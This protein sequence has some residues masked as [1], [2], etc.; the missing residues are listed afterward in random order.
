M[1]WP[2]AFVYVGIAFAIALGLKW[3]LMGLSKL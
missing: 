2:Q 3:F 1:S